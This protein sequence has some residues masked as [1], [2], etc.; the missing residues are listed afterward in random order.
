MNNEKAFNLLTLLMFNLIILLSIS[1]FN[2]NYYFDFNKSKISEFFSLTMNFNNFFKNKDKNELVNIE[3]KYQKNGDKYYSVDS[4][5]Y[6]IEDGII[7]G[8][9]NKKISIIQNDRYLLNYIGDFILNI[10]EGDYV[11]KNTIIAITYDY[12]YIEIS[13]GENNV[14][15]EEYLHNSF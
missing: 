6:S 10:H 4:R 15:Y 13:N 9:N 5:I 8:L 3:N 14:T 1:I 12:F 7:I 11:E 2:G